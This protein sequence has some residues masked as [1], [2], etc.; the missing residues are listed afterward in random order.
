MKMNWATS[1]YKTT[2]INGTLRFCH[3]TMPHHVFL[4][5]EDNKDYKCNNAKW[6]GL[7]W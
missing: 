5:E 7:K 1:T 4:T 2:N 6:Q 3:V